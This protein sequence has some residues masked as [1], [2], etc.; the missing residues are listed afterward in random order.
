MGILTW[1]CFR[2]FVIVQLVL[3]K[4]FG[5]ESIIK[6]ILNSEQELKV[7]PKVLPKS[8]FGGVLG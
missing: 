1:K 2:Q 4:N 3:L 6:F 8:K 7:L 5:N